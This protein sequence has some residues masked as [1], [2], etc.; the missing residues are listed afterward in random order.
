MITRI[1]K[2]TFRPDKVQANGGVRVYEED[3]K[4]AELVRWE[5]EL[6]CTWAWLIAI[7]VNSGGYAYD[8]HVPKDTIRTGYSM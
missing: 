4:D 5:W 6:D 8:F 3:R 7:P 2:M 1:V